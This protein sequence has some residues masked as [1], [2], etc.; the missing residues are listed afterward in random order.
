VAALQ[1][2]NG[3]DALSLVWTFSRA[4]DR[5]SSIKQDN[6]VALRLEITH[7]EQILEHGSKVWG[8]ENT[9]VLA[10]SNNLA[11]GYWSLGRYQEAAKLFEETLVIMERVLGPEHPNT[12]NSRNNLALG[13]RYLGQYQEAVELF[14]ESLRIGERVLGP[15]HPDTL[16]S[17]HNLANAYRAVG[18]DKEADELESKVE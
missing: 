11:I 18:R 9:D 12:L 10:F 15:E 5:L 6:P 7:Y 1:A 17:R 2:T 4:R 16:Q 13:Y 8:A 3:E 14:E